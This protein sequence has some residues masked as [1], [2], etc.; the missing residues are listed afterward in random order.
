VTQPSRLLAT[1]TPTPIACYGGTSRITVSATGGTSPYTGTGN[2]NVLAGTYSYSVTD[3]SGCTSVTSVVVTQPTRLTS[4]ATA[5]AILCYGGT[6]TVNVTAG[7]GTA[8]YAGT[9]SYTA[10]AGTRTYSVTDANG[11]TSTA[12]VTISQ[13]AQLNAF[14]SSGNVNCYGGTTPVSVTASGGTAPY[15]GTGNFPQSAG[16][17]I[18]QVQDANRCAASVSITITQPLQLTAT[19]TAQPILCNGGS[20]SVNVQANGGTQPYNGTGS[21]QVT[22]GNYSYTV[23]DN[24]GCSVT[25]NLNVSQPQPLSA[26]VTTLDATCFTAGSATASAMGGTGSYSYLWSNGAVTPSVGNLQAGT[27]SVTVTDQNGCTG[28]ASGTVRLIANYPA[29]AGPISGQTN[30]RLNAAF[31]YSVVPVSGATSYRWTLPAN[32]TGTSTGNSISITFLN[33]FRSGTICVTPVNACGDGVT[34]CITVSVPT[35]AAPGGGGKTKDNIHLPVGIGAPGGMI[36]EG[37]GG[38][39][40]GQEVVRTDSHQDDIRHLVAY[41]NPTTGKVII[42]F[43]GIRDAAYRLT[44]MDMAGNL[45]RTDDMTGEEDMVSRV[46]DLSGLAKGIYSVW[47][48]RKDGSSQKTIRLVVQ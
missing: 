1:A 7:G 39:E 23:V 20:T 4:A 26:S 32:C 45:L 42:G 38:A 8:P 17:Y 13:P 47:V 21:F 15:S 27:Y 44:V 12:T 43:A 5:S 30:I 11:C 48:Q 3:A 40:A 18:Y 16:T 10:L 46:Y 34:S 33:G 41:P 24:N 36:T 29:A 25:T 6:S 37:E 2:Y 14:A 31:T 22:A 19:A 9:G 28:S 35:I